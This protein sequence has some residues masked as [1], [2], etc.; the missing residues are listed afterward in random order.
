MQGEDVLP[1]PAS[2]QGC[3]LILQRVK[4]LG[5]HISVANLSM[6]GLQ[7]LAPSITATRGLDSNQE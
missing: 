1:A 7:T 3:R 2:V 6:S 4:K 5:H